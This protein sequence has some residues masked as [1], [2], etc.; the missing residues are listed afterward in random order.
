MYASLISSVLYGTNK[1]L[2]AIVLLSNSNFFQSF[3]GCNGRSISFQLYWLIRGLIFDI[4]CG[5]FWTFWKLNAMA[6]AY[7][8]QLLSLFFGFILA[9]LFFSHFR[10][11]IYEHPLPGFILLS[12]YS[13]KLTPS[14]IN[15][16]LYIDSSNSSWNF[17]KRDLKRSLIISYVFLPIKISILSLFVCIV[18]ISSES[19][20]ETK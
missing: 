7:W 9:F 5:S 11:S 4:L 8:K 6:K 15:P 2:R 1:I 20:E 19:L 3:C 18:R 10:E 16:L 13:N 12:L 17:C 14:T